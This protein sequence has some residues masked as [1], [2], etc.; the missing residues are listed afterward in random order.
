MADDSFGM[1]NP[2]RSSD[3]IGTKIEDQGEP[4]A[5]NYGDEQNQ[6]VL[7]GDSEFAFESERGAS[8]AEKVEFMN[9]RNSSPIKKHN[10]NSS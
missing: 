3:L 5:I 8:L 2:S 7:R 1:R 6:K 9:N 10:R 4:G